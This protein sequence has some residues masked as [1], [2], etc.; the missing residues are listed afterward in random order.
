MSKNYSLLFII[1]FVRV[2]LQG[3]QSTLQAPE[4]IRK[5]TAI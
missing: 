2:P 3:N 5:H 1:F 4:F